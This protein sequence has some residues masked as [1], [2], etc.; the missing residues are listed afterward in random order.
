[1]CDP[2][3]APRPP[4][5]TGDRD[6]P[7]RTRARD[8][9]G[10]LPRAVYTPTKEPGIAPAASLTG[11]GDN[12]HRSRP[13]SRRDKEMRSI[14]LSAIVLIASL[15]QG[16]ASFCRGANACWYLPP[17]TNKMQFCYSL[18]D[19]GPTDLH[20]EPARC[21]CWVR[22]DGPGYISVQWYLGFVKPV[23]FPC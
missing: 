9:S 12:P 10:H 13:T 1:L 5:G 17:N 6:L 11:S 8:A 16:H 7:R 21:G 2:A 20:G 18:Y 15:S 23:Y 3:K 22:R 14:V 19:W 4:E